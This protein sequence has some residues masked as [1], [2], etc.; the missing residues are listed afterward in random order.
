[1][2]NTARLMQFAASGVP[3]EEWTLNNVQ[4][5]FAPLGQAFLTNGLWEQ[6]AWRDDGLRFF[7]IRR[8]T[9]DVYSRAGQSAWETYPSQN[10]G[11]SKNLGAQDLIPYGLAFKPDGT[12]MY[13]TGQQNSKV[14]EY[15]L[16]SAWN[17]LT[18]SFNQDYSLSF[19]SDA[20]TSIFF[21]SDGLNMF[22]GRNG[23]SSGVYSYSLSTA[24]DI[25]TASAVT[26]LS[27]SGTWGIAF[28][29]SG[30]KLYFAN[31]ST[32]FV[33][34]T[35]STPWDL[36]TAGATSVFTDSTWYNNGTTVSPDSN[37]RTRH[38]SFNDDGSKVYLTTVPATGLYQGG[39]YN[40][41][42][43]TA[44]D[45]T[46][47]ARQ[48]ASARYYDFP[49]I[50]TKTSLGKGGLRFSPDGTSFF[51]ADSN[52]NTIQQYDLSVAWGI[53]SASY[54]SQVSSSSANPP[55]DVALSADGTLLFI[56]NDVDVRTFT[57]GTAYDITTASLLRTTNLSISNIKGIFFKE[58]GLKFYIC[59][60]ANFRQ[61]TLATPYDLSTASSDGLV[62]GSGDTYHSLRIDAS[63][64]KLLV[65]DYGGGLFPDR[66]YLREFTISTAWDITAGITL[67]QSYD[68]SEDVGGFSENGPRGMDVSPNG[69]LL[70]SPIRGQDII[71]QYSLD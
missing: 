47:A 34:R 28:N 2:S 33:Y 36:S 48:L 49:S 5:P 8:D 42:L 67:T 13:I 60:G 55:S 46:T 37:R 14:Y 10:L 35:L 21:S 43:S 68:I 11:G 26:S 53:S 7:V 3:G 30:T 17:I 40:Y 59:V 20:P 52:A 41:D 16:S 58:D 57:L 18:A 54:V 65:T 25:S 69:A 29:S 63:G 24:W 61:Y 44:Y 38:I 50:N 45:L 19:G 4:R 62:V 70:Y 6:V 56:C 66:V 32:S 22:V 9:R 27:Y 39:I 12:K 31:N 23:S 71:V 15:N 64:T 1:M 51:I